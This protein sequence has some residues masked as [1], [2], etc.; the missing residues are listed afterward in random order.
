MQ[1]NKEEVK[2]A[3]RPVPTEAAQQKPS[4]APDKSAIE[5]VQ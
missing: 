3:E 1:A 4:T 2:K 5:K